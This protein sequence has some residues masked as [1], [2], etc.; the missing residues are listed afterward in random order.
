MRTRTT[1]LAILAVALCL[2]AFA[3]KQAPPAP[4]T[5]KNFSLPE[6]RKF[7]LDNG[8]EVRMIHYGTVPKVSM[9]LTVEGGNSSE[10]ADQVWL[11]DLVGNLMDEGTT[12]RSAEQVALEAARMGGSLETSVASTFTSVRADALSEFTPDMVRLV[13][14]VARNPL[15]PES[16]LPRLKADLQ[17]ELSIAKSQQQSLANEKF[18][19]TLYPNQPFGRLYPTPEMINGFTPAQVR[20]FYQKNFGAANSR[21]YI[22]GMFDD[23][24]TEAAIRAAFGTWPAGTKAAPVMASGKSGRTVQVIDRPGAVQSTIYIGLPVVDPSSAD[25]IPLQVTNAI[26][27][28]SFG[29]R[30]TSNIREQKGYTYSPHAVV[31]PFIHASHWAEIADVTTNVT[32]PALKEILYEIT[33]LRNEPPTAAELTGIQNYLAGTFVLQNSSRAGI[34]NLLRFVDQQGLSDEYLKTYVQRIYAMAP[35]DVQNIAQKYFNPDAM[36]IVVAGDV[37]QIK[38]QL[39]PYGMK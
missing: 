25:W 13:G 6:I 31:T 38:D 18:L 8:L 12:S 16:E 28:G 1:L 21:F 39:T 2:P 30:I 32:G 35:A 7:T 37:A 9:M 20:D 27:G 4:G 22:A 33:R 17:R 11:A 5:P 15:L 34:I 14:D 19:A 3:Q 23:A 29:S 26:L 10:A 24:A 36:T